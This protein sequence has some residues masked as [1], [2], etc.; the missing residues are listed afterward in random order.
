MALQSSILTILKK[1][2][3]KLLDSK[4]IVQKRRRKRGEE[5]T[6]CPSWSVRPL[7]DSVAE[8]RVPTCYISV[9]SYRQKVRSGRYG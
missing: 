6:K 4:S 7:G 1:N 3:T 9:K 2:K 8:Q 5:G